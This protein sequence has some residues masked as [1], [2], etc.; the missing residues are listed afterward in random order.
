MSDTGIGIVPEILPRIFDLFSQADQSLARTQGGLGI[1]LTM[2][3][4]LVELHGGKVEARSA[5]LGLGSEFTIRLPALPGEAEEP[6][7]PDGPRERLPEVPPRRILVVDDIADSADSLAQMLALEGH[8]TRAAYSGPSALTI[9]CDFAPEV[10]LLDIGMPGMD[11]YEVARRIRQE[12]ESQPPLL[13]ALTGYVQESDRR[14]AREA[15]F[16]RHLEKPVDLPALRDLLSHPPAGGRAPAS[17][18]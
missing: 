15:G 16:D 18:T 17:T 4:K 3:K 13:V 14:T 2:V 8:E 12:S 5:G 11:G 6:V 10:V 9:L 1:G 7:K